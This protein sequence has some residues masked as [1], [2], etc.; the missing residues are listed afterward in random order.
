MLQKAHLRVSAM[1]LG[2]VVVLGWV[3]SVWALEMAK[4]LA[5][6]QVP[7]MQQCRHA[8]C[9]GSGRHQRNETPKGCPARATSEQ[10]TA[11]S[12]RNR[13]HPCCQRCKPSNQHCQC[14]SL[15]RKATTDNH[16]THPNSRAVCFHRLC[17]S[18]QLSALQKQKFAW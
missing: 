10:D 1:A 3:A 5:I 16:H 15:V 4:V 17:T 18:A 2:W 14:T 13:H 8:G 11:R 12:C 7:S 6:H 9:S